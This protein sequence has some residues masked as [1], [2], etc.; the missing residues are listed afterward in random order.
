MRILRVPYRSVARQLR[1][2]A[3]KVKAGLL[4]FRWA[5]VNWRNPSP[6]NVARVGAGLLSSVDVV[7][8]NLD[9]RSDRLSDFSAEMK[10]LGVTDWRRVPATNGAQF[11]PHLP[12]FFAGSIGCTLSHINALASVD[13]QNCVAAMICEDDAEFL[14]SR[15]EIEELLENFLGDDRLDVLALYGR[16][17]GASTPISTH[18]RIVMGLVGRVCYVVKPHMA[19]PLAQRFETGIPLLKG[20]RRRGKGDQMWRKLQRRGYFF[21]SPRF[22]AV[23]NRAGYSDIEGRGLGPR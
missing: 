12:A 2:A 1:R 23:R 8:I 9:N 20:G 6:A 19:L 4:N 22:P 5:R 21:A 14:V 13:W 18:L 11:F 3:R 15:A 17:R 10:R 7:V 16:A